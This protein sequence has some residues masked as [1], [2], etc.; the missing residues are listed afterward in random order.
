MVVCIGDHM[1]G[2]RPYIYFENNMI[3]YAYLKIYNKS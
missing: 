2:I 3:Q 1:Y